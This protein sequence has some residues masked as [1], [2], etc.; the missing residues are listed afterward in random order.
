[1]CPGRRAN[2]SLEKA[3]LADHA[4]Q[5]QGVEA[6]APGLSDHQV[7]IIQAVSQVVEV[8]WRRERGLLAFLT[9]QGKD[10][11]RGKDR[12]A[13]QSDTQKMV[14]KPEAVGGTD[15]HRFSQRLELQ[16]GFVIHAQLP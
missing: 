15:A 9:C 3:F 11:A 4:E 5:E 16:A 1:M 2:E 12:R 6:V 14:G 8:G 10:L 13:I 7:V